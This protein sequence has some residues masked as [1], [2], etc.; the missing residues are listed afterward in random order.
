LQRRLDL[1]TRQLATNE[2]DNDTLSLERDRAVKKLQ[3]ACENIGDLMDKLEVREREL[4][5][6][7]KQ[8]DAT[9]QSRPDHGSPRSETAAL[10]QAYETVLCE[11]ETFQQTIAMLRKDQQA[12]QQEVESLRQDNTILRR[13]NESL[14]T[15]N[16]SLRSNARALM[17]ENESLR[18]H[19]DNTEGDIDAIRE[20]IA[21]LQHEIQG[22]EQEKAT[23]KED[24]DSLV[25]H[26]EKYFNEN[27]ILRK[28]NSGFER[29]VHEL[30]D[31]II[32]LK[33]EVEFLKQQ[34]DHYRPVGRDKDLSDPFSRGEEDE[35]EED[36]ENMTSA[37]IVPDIELQQ[38]ENGEEDGATGQSDLPPMDLPTETQ[39]ITN[40]MDRDLDIR[41]TIEKD[42]SVP[43]EIETRASRKSKPVREPSQRVAF[44]LPE[45]SQAAKPRSNVAAKRRSVVH[46]SFN[47][48]FARPISFPVDQ[49][50]TGYQSTE[51]TNTHS[52]SLKV[53]AGKDSSMKMQRPSR[54]TSM[55]DTTSHSQRA[56]SRAEHRS[57]PSTKNL[58][59]DRTA[60][61]FVGKETC[62]ALSNDARRILDGLCE[63]TCRNCVV[64]ARIVS[65]RGTVSAAEMADGKKRVKV[66]RPVPV[67]D[68]QADVDEYDAT[69]RPARSPGHALALVIKS[70][71]D[72]A[73]HLSMELAKLQ[74]RYNELDKSM[75]K[76]DRRVLVDEI[77]RTLRMLESKNDQVYALYDVLEGQK[78]AGQAMSEEELEMTI[79]S[80]TGMTT[81][82]LTD[83]ATW[84]GIQG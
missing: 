68:R 57:G 79:Q 29:T 47:R 36:D 30:H 46:E 22:L 51:V 62:P 44:S 14:M 69:M 45:S 38:K 23:F 77:N 61:G 35:I 76:R 54:K 56:A 63:H 59:M 8:L 10:R 78:V 4:N 49:D 6:T 81:R 67:T 43:P 70:L 66:S 40:T 39:D 1:N 48:D 42:D 58:T 31:E 3:E 25:R 64:C 15:E 21:N 34:L 13:E 72:E 83:N 80:I 53:R 20:E 60:E 37:F 82:D 18:K 28:E 7:Q 52:M 12:T 75:G 32:R 55:R 26:N 27:K 74:A 16:R 11:N 24:N 5:E 50:S 84:G 65:H 73:A 9:L 17:S 71:E 41:P 33:D 19:G 2:K